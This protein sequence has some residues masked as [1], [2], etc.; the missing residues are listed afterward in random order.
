MSIRQGQDEELVFDQNGLGDHRTDVAGPQE[1]G[2]GGD[3]MDEKDEEIAHL[4]II[5]IP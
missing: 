4:R 1:P 2:E 3:N 5:A